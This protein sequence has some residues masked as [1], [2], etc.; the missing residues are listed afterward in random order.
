MEL[1]VGVLGFEASSDRQQS[2]VDR[3][4]IGFVQTVAPM[5]SADDRLLA[6]VG[7][8]RFEF[9]REQQ[10]DDGVPEHSV[11]GELRGVQP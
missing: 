3:D 7:D 10:K 2:P 5:Q 6:A 9:A 4:R 1:L 8:D 11:R